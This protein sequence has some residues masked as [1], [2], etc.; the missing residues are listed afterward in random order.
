MN[1]DCADEWI[2][3]HEYQNALEAYDLCGEPHFVGPGPGGKG[4]VKFETVAI[5]KLVDLLSSKNLSPVEL[6]S[7]CD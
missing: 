2:T 5:E 1:E 4:Y 7:A 6:F 3:Y